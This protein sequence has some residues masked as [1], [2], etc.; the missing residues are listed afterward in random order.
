MAN[1]P[2]KQPIP[3]E[4]DPAPDA[5]GQ[6]LPKKKRVSKADLQ[7]AGQLLRYAQPYRGRFTAA[8]AALT[9]GGVLSLCLPVLIQM[10]IDVA[11]GDKN[12]NLQRL[13]EIF[14]SLNGVAGLIVGVLVSSAIVSYFRVVWWAEVG[15]RA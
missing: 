5:A 2:A 1:T 10:L 11:H 13:P 15:E 12:T 7:R 8:L 6:T 9:L 14:R 4:T 3:Q